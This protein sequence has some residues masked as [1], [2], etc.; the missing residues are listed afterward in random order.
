MEGKADDDAAFMSS[1]NLPQ[2]VAFS[3]SVAFS[4][5]LRR[6][7]SP[8]GGCACGRRSAVRVT[9]FFVTTEEERRRLQCA[10]VGRRPCAATW[11]TFGAE[12][13]HGRDGREEGQRVGDGEKGGDTASVL[14]GRR[15]GE[16][17]RR[18]RGVLSSRS[19]MSA[20]ALVTTS[21]ARAVRRCCSSSRRRLHGEQRLRG[22]MPRGWWTGGGRVSAV[23]PSLGCWSGLAEDAAAPSH[24][25]RCHG[26]RSRRR[27]RARCSARRYAGRWRYRMQDEKRRRQMM[28]RG[29][30]VAG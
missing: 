27:S 20:V 14:A 29:V 7:P 3:S 21:A 17:Q 22:R 2:F 9:V 6:R 16:W 13:R 19:A 18:P 24:T 11:T 30:G 5:R 1:P 28:E 12:Q 26:E 8:V 4:K 23:P 25:P 10:M 15:R